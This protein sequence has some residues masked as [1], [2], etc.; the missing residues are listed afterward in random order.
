MVKS[1]TAFTVIKLIL[2]T[3][4]FFTDVTIG[5]RL[6]GKKEMFDFSVLFHLA[7]LESR[8]Q[9]LKKIKNKDAKIHK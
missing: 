7:I 9:W 3:F 2:Q 1:V 8:I 4:I 5:I 6:L